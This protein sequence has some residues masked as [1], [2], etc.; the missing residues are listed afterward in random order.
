M[1]SVNTDTSSVTGVVSSSEGQCERLRR[2]ENN[3]Q[4][5]KAPHDA[6]DGK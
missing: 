2:I 6:K 5:Q 1:E 3:G 4:K